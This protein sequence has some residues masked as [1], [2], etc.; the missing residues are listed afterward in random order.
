MNDLGM[1][2]NNLPH[3]RTCL[4]TS[5]SPLTTA[6]SP[7]SVS[8]K[9][10]SKTSASTSIEPSSPPSASND[11]FAKPQAPLPHMVS[12]PKQRNVLLPT[13]R[14]FLLPPQQRLNPSPWL[15]GLAPWEGY[16][17][18]PRPQR[19]VSKQKRNPVKLKKSISAP[20]ESVLLIDLLEELPPS[21]PKCLEPST[22]DDSPGVGAGTRHYTCLP[23]ASPRKNNI[24]TKN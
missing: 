12:Q 10:P 3:L 2:F 21:T 6:A 14:R 5:P 23:P 19:T 24:V 4:S 17:S 7:A 8:T 20:S 9:G 11:P 22:S 13:P 18:R 1:R 16:C 15:L